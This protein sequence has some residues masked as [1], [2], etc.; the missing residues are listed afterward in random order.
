MQQRR[1]TRDEWKGIIEDWQG[2]GQSQ[3]KYCSR[4]RLV[5]SAFRYWFRKLARQP[6][7]GGNEGQVRAIEISKI[8]IPFPL[9]LSHRTKRTNI[10]ACGIV[11][12]LGGTN[13]SVTLSGR[14]SLEQLGRVIAACEGSSDHAQA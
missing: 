2:A 7:K 6:V 4:K 13:A 3:R 9:M 8:G 5:Y 11:I 14:L 10:N 1:Q 12:P